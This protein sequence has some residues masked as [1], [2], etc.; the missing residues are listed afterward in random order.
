MKLIVAHK[1]KEKESCFDATVF[2]DDLDRAE[3]NTMA[4]G[5]FE[6]V[7]K[8]EDEFGNETKYRV[9]FHRTDLTALEFI[10]KGLA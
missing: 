7:V 6:I 3:A 4:D 1:S 9:I 8:D 5:G 10:L 2:D